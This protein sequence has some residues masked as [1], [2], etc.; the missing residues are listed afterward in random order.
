[1]LI[2]PYCSESIGKKQKKI[3]PPL[4]A[5]EGTVSYRDDYVL[6]KRIHSNEE[7]NAYIYYMSG[8]MPGKQQ[9]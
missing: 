7:T 9:M 1:M 6:S 2:L 5:L 4:I 3:E 8:T